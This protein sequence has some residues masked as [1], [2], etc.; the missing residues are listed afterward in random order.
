MALLVKD[1]DELSR[2]LADAAEKKAAAA[3]LKIMSGEELFDAV[4]NGDLDTMKASLAVG[5][6]LAYENYV[7]T[8]EI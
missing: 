5:A 7:S 2:V 4:V 1:P 8:S 3:L 6:S